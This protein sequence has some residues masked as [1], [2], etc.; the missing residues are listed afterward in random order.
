M[1]TTWQPPA[2]RDEPAVATTRHAHTQ[3]MLSHINVGCGLTSPS[4]NWQKPLRVIGYR[5]EI[6][7]DP[8]KPV[9]PPRK[10]MDAYSPHRAGLAGQSGLIKEG[11]G[12]GADDS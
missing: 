2:L 8:S 3:P 9:A 5:G 4:E 12:E 10:L 11:A 1:W 7:F 6:A